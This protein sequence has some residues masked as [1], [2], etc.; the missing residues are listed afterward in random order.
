MSESEGYNGLLLVDKP[1]GISSFDVIRRLRRIILG[2]PSTSSGFRERKRSL[3]I[4]HAGTLDPAATGLM[5]ML[6]GPACKKA[7]DFSKLDKEYMAEITLGATSSTGD[8]EG[9]ITR[10][11]EHKPAEEAITALLERFRGPITQVPSIYSAIK[12]NG[13]E[14]YKLARRGQQIEVPSRQVTVHELELL[15][16]AYPIVRLRTKVSSGTYIRTLAEDIGSALETG[17]YLTDLRRTKVGDYQI[18]AAV[19][20]EGLESDGVR[21]AILQI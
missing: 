5:L 11:N 19:E 15:G 18:K 9:S 14:A 7:G 10:V 6:F 2:D 4:G 1:A 20:L 13:Q 17:A 21:A 8:R 12:I 16:Y 3:K